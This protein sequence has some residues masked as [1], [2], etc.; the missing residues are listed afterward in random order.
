MRQCAGLGRQRALGFGLAQGLEIHA[1]AANRVLTSD[2]QPYHKRVAAICAEPRPRKQ[3]LAALHVQTT[4]P[5][6]RDPRDTGTAAPT[7]VRRVGHQDVVVGQAAGRHVSVKVP[8]AALRGT[9]QPLLFS[10]SDTRACAC[11]TTPASFL[12]LLAKASSDRLPVLWSCRSYSQSQSGPAAAQSAG[13]SPPMGQARA[14]HAHGCTAVQ[15]TPLCTIDA[16]K[17]SH[18][19]AA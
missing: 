13:S 3:V 12:T 1:R 4:M 15:R 5:V 16:L 6:V 8:L 14:V 11:T 17:P 2:L 7:R 9:K 19:E 18:Q 10:N